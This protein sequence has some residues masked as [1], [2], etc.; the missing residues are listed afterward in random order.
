MF[1]APVKTVGGL[2]EIFITITIPSPNIPQKLQEKKWKRPHNCF[3]I[4]TCLTSL[5]KFTCVLINLEITNVN[6]KFKTEHMQL[7]TTRRC[8]FRSQT[9][10][11]GR[12]GGILRHE[13]PLYPRQKMVS[14]CL[15]MSLLQEIMSRGSTDFAEIGSVYCNC[16]AWNV[17]RVQKCV[18]KRWCTAGLMF[19]KMSSVNIFFHIVYIFCEGKFSIV[20]H[21]TCAAFKQHS[22]EKNKNKQ[23]TTIVWNQWSTD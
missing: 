21:N 13:S 15:V 11:A 20:R 9:H 10:V 7:I 19:N 14:P 18:L 16:L 8:R 2:R 6:S 5:N 23:T 4:W 1:R 3:V 17:S 12:G 22:G